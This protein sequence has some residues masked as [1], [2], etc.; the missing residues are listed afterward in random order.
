MEKKFYFEKF[1]EIIN[2]SYNWY[3]KLSGSIWAKDIGL[4][5]E[6]VNNINEKEREILV[7]LFQA[8]ADAL[9]IDLKDCEKDFKAL[10]MKLG[11]AV[12]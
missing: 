4:F 8:Y 12:A 3:F 5:L 2:F 1:E 6:A 7:G 10:Y 11:G 9:G